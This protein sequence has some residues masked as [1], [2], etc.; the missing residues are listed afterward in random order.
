MVSPALGRLKRK[1]GIKASE[2]R[3]LL[4]I[5]YGSIYA[6]FRQILS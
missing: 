4:L 3:I 5:N 1:A 2:E 6:N